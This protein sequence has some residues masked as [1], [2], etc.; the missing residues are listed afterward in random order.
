MA[1][2]RLTRQADRDLGSIYLYTLENFGLAQAERYA[3]DMKACFALLAN[4]PRM[5]RMVEAIRPGLRRHEHGAH[6]IFYREDNGAGGLLILTV[7]HMRMRPD[8]KL[9]EPT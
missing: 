3:D 7:V 9:D 1:S 2:F 8:L 6:V 5:G 4:N